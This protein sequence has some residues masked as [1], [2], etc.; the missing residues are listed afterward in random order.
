M[1][2][3][4]LLACI[5]IFAGCTMTDNASPSTKLNQNTASGEFVVK[6]ASSFQ[7]T[8]AKEGR[9]FLFLSKNNSREP[10]EQLWPLSEYKNDIFAKN[11]EFMSHSNGMILS[12]STELMT[13]ASFD[14]DSIPAGEYSLQVLWHQD[15]SKPYINSPGNLYSEVKTINI[16]TD[17]T[18]NVTLSKSIEDEQLVNH[19]L[20]KKV[21]IQ[22]KVLSEFWGRPYSVT[23]SVL[24][25]HSYDE[26]TQ[27]T[28]PIRYN[29]AGYGG[30][31]TR[32]ERAVGSEEFM[33]WWE[34]EEA[35]QIITVYLDSAGP[36]GDNY[37]LDSANNGPFGQSLINEL[38]PA[39]ESEYR[40]KGS[41]KYRFTD[42]CSTGGWV[43]LALQLYYPEAFNGVFSYSPD[44]VDFTAY[45]LANIYEDENVFYNKWNNLRPVARTVFGDPIV[46]LKEF[47]AFENIQGVSNDYRTSGGQFS[48][49]TALYSPKG[50][51]GLPLALFDP[52][53]GEINPA[54]AEA[55]KKYDLKLHTEEN[56]AE[57]GPKLQDKIYIWMGDMDH[58]FLNPATRKLS[59][60]LES[61]VNPVSNAV[62]E[63]TPMAGHCQNFG[64]KIVL[65]QIQQRLMAID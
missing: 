6:V 58:F 36:F 24:L 64:D 39:I 35:P 42:G 57:L 21:T 38:I 33:Q 51:D 25:P 43:S 41:G 7:D 12:N 30:R 47:I 23:A 62:V 49:H 14:L 32:V 16:T 15:T 37:Q 2:T 17:F 50:E 34:S 4:L 8:A 22:S 27:A 3:I 10:R 9:I 19:P 31:Y 60:F 48:A 63:F 54:V 20:V 61:T 29:V 1:K 13:T 26:D 55:W 45:Q 65:E 18:E 59:Q 40:A 46:T 44:S 11:V 52:E 28:Y 5:L 53:T 56:W